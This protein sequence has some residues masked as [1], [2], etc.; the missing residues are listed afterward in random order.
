[1]VTSS[2]NFDGKFVPGERWSLTCSYPDLTDFGS[3]QVLHYREVVYVYT[4]DGTEGGERCPATSAE[5]VNGSTAV[6]TFEQ[7]LSDDETM[8]TVLVNKKDGTRFGVGA[9]DISTVALRKGNNG[10]QFVLEF[11]IFI[12]SS[13][14]T[15][16]I[17]CN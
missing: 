4:A 3:L 12:K 7:F 8:W 17:P 16:N 1:M 9:I 2:T 15:Q 5:I 14:F 13:P 10:L 6:V 11:V